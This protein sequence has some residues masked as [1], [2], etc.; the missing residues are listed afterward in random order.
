VLNPKADPRSDPWR[1]LAELIKSPSFSLPVAGDRVYPLGQ[2]GN[3]TDP[4][5]GEH[6]FHSGVDFAAPAGTPVRAAADGLVVFSG[7]D[8]FGRTVKVEHSE[9]FQTFYRFLSEID[10]RVGQKVR[11]GE[12]L[13]KVGFSG[14]VTAPHLHFEMHFLGKPLDPSTYLR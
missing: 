3:R 9:R 12:I 13:G 1:Q 6:S 5:S 11:Q 14:L 7:W 2:F 8:R 10:V 4:F